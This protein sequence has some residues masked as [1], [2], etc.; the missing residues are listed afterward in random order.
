M[1]NANG[2]GFEGLYAGDTVEFTVPKYHAMCGGKKRAAVLPL[3]VF[4][5]H[6][7]VR[8]GSFGYTVDASN[9]VRLVR[10]GKRHIEADARESQSE[11]AEESRANEG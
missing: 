3:L 11:I 9:F 7:Q 6:V 10:R 2:P 8:Y 4:D 5:D 1:I